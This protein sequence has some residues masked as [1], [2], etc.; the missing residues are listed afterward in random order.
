MAH[1]RTQELR[2]AS[3]AFHKSN[4]TISKLRKRAFRNGLEGSRR[5]VALEPIACFVIS[6]Y[7]AGTYVIDPTMQGKIALFQSSRNRGMGAEVF[8]LR[9]DIVFSQG[10][11]KIGA[12]VSFEV[13]HFRVAAKPSRWGKLPGPRDE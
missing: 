1:G 8:H 12:R 2:I 6:R 3:I 13:S 4:P 10:E 11:K 5:C 7:H 9:D